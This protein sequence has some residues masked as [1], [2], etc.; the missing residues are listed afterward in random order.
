VTVT[1]FELAL[2]GGPGRRAEFE[3]LLQ[4]LE[5]DHATA[6]TRFAA[7]A[8]DTREAINMRPVALAAF[9]ESDRYTDIHE[10]S[11]ALADTFGV[12]PDIAMRAW[13]GEWCNKRSAFEARFSA[14]SVTYAS[15]YLGGPGA[16]RYGIFCVALKPN[17]F[18]EDDAW[19]CLAGDSLRDF[20]A[21]DGTFDVA[22]IALNVSDRSH[23]QYLLALSIELDQ[24]AATTPDDWPSIVCSDS[25]NFE[26]IFARAVTSSDVDVV[27]VCRQEIAAYAQVFTRVAA[28]GSLAVDERLALSHYHLVSKML[29][30]RNI[31]LEVIE[32]M[33]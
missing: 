3:A 16:R 6:L 11:L 19:A 14:K 13:L 32:C 15:L 29:K 31:N 23:R 1:I 20:L 26:V 10:L 30:S 22:R 28:G 9:L 7:A 2:Q 12:D 4:Q 24:L 5:P 18:H 27:R 25:R 8:G 21:P 33:S 17:V